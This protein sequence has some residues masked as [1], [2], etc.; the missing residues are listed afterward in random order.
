MDVPEEK[1]ETDKRTCSQRLVS[2]NITALTEIFA[3]CLTNDEINEL[4]AVLS[5]IQSVLGI[6]LVQRECDEDETPT[7]PPSFL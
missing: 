1:N 3:E 4:L 6:I 7:L 2:L 5:L